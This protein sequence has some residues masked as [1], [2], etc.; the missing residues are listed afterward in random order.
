MARSLLSMGLILLFTS[1]AL[2]NWPQFR[3]DK[4]GHATGTNLPDSWD[5]TKN[6]AWKTDIPGKG[7][8]SPIIW[9]DKVFLTTVVD[10]A[11]AVAPKTGYYAP[12]DSKIP[13]GQHR[14]LVL[15]IDRNNGKVLWEKT[16]HIGL[17]AQKVHVKNTYAS[18][19]P[20]TDGERLYAYFG[21]QGLHCY[22]LNGK[23]LWTKKWGSFDMRLGWGTGSSPMVYKDRLY[24]LND[25]E[26]KSFLVALNKK[27]G[28]EI[29]RVEREESSSWATPYIWENPQRTELIT[30]AT[31]KVRSY[32]LAGKL[33]WELG[34]MSS[35]C[36]PT[37]VTAHGLLFITSGY[38]FGKPRPLFAIRPGAS[39]D[40]SL[41][42]D[43]TS[44]QFI[45]WYKDPAGPY[46]P[47]PLILGDYL[48]ILESRGFLT[49]FDA[50]T[51]KEV[52]GKQRVGGSAYTASPWSYDGKIFCLSEDGETHVI[53]A[54]PEFKVLGKNNLEEMS[55][56]TP[57]IAG[58]SLFIRTFS[59]LYCIQNMG[60]KAGAK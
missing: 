50:K 31:K 25:N 7:W 51:G 16:A 9:G 13:P 22:D 3:G 49:C 19:T 46:H 41:K 26:Q 2:S 20:A 12:T 28:E 36:V 54:G 43:E 45:A 37:P 8:S 29:W 42:K 30:C 38:E 60:T 52:Y 27:T 57:A 58:N 44:N 53:Q 35:I 11:K 15:C 55:L 39:G 6:V 21:N 17:P 18:E 48:Y 14:W 1:L 47:S 40:I 24:V 56:A 33:L 34:G 5:T 32:D 4:Q 10:E 59:K 23:E